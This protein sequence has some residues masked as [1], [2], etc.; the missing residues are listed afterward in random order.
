MRRNKPNSV[1]NHPWKTEVTEGDS[2]VSA[3]T[4]ESWYDAVYEPSFAA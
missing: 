3:A 2:G 1:D 4:I